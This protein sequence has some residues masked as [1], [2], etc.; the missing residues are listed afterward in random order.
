VR[1]AE[2]VTTGWPLTARGRIFERLGRSYADNEIVGA[3][4]TG[5]AGVGKL[6]VDDA[7]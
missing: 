1:D 4:L 6:A 7:D 5:T 3:V 2:V